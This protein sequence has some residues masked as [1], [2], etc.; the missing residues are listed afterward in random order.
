M[1]D[2]SVPKA[3]KEIVRNHLKNDWHLGVAQGLEEY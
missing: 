2:L 1:A 3:S